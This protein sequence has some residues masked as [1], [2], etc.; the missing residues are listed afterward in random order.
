MSFKPDDITHEA[1]VESLL[2]TNN[3]LL[4]AVI[5]LLCD[6]NDEDPSQIIEAAEQ[7]T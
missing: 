6:Q 7:Y 4:M 1:Y 2:E 5:I 3:T